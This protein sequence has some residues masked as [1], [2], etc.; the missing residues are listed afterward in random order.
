M[1][2]KIKTFLLF[3]SRKSYIVTAQLHNHQETGH[4]WTHRVEGIIYQSKLYTYNGLYILFI[5]IDLFKSIHLI[6]NI[7]V[8]GLFFKSWGRRAIKK[9]PKKHLI[10]LQ[11]KIRFKKWG[12]MKNRLKLRKKAT[13]AL[14]LYFFNFKIKYLSCNN[15]KRISALF[16]FN[17]K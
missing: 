11:N 5:Y 7:F 14:F 8:F 4:W 9:I 17:L 10:K 2:K 12:V 6:I 16:L 15:K 3:S 1:K 13:K